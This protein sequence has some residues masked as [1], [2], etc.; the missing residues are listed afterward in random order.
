MI[1]CHTTGEP[2][3]IT[4]TAQKIA[5]TIYIMLRDKV[6]YCDLGINYYEQKYKSRILHN[7]KNRPESFGYQLVRISTQ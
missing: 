1:P 3:A 2:A 4:A 7:L 6:E 5:R